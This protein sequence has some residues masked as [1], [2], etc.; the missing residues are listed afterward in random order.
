MLHM[1]QIQIVQLQVSDH[2]I[3]DECH[4]IQKVFLSIKLSCFQGQ[5]MSPIYLNYYVVC[6]ENLMKYSFYI[7]YSI[8]ILLYPIVLLIRLNDTHLFW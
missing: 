6:H 5:S 7:D 1:F 2:I 8:L 3:E 4:E